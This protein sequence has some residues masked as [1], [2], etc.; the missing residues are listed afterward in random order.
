MH[1]K[2][3]LLQREAGPTIQ[4]PY[5]ETL[6]PA[7]KILFANRTQRHPARESPKACQGINPAVDLVTSL[8]RAQSSKGRATLGHHLSIL[9]GA[10]WIAN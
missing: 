9:D 5:E 2:H 7:R 6:P 1:K 8:L 3:L 4:Q 10:L